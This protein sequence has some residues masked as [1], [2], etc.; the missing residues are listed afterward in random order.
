MNNLLI[1]QSGGPTAA[2]NATLAGTIQAA[3]MNTKVDN[4]YGAINGIL[5]VFK[6]K[7]IDLKEKVRKT[8]DFELLCQTPASVLASCRFLLDDWKEND[9]QYKRFIEIIHKHKSPILFI[10][11]EMIPWIRC[12]NYLSI[13][14]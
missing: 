4:I 11:V 8:D 6:E 1:A 14:P 5:R 2:I 10:S 12:V 9:T 3:L 13:R 7:F